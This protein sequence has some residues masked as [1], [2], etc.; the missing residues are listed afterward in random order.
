MTNHYQ[1]QP[2]PS[3]VGFGY[4]SENDASRH[5]TYP[6]MAL[7][8]EGGSKY[9]PP[10][11]PGS[12]LKSAL[13]VPGTPGRL[14]NPL[15]PTFQE[16]QVLE[17]QEEMTDKRQAKD[18]VGHDTGLDVI[19]NLSN[20][21][22]CHIESE[23]ERTNSEDDASRRQLQLQSHRSFHVGNHVFHLQRHQVIT[24]TQQPP[25]MGIGNLDMAADCSPVH[26]VRLARHVN[27]HYICAMETR[28]P[29]SGESRSLLYCFRRGFLRLQHHH[30][31]H[32]C[33]NPQRQQGQW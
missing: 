23:D 4:M 29:A 15:S 12:P 27:G 32:W 5:A 17:K 2:Q 9:M 30:V 20:Y 14:I 1:P 21:F 31:G 13:K 6:G 24:A 3:D 26:L 33:R 7:E 22:C 8:E 28:S 19:D 10:P 16:E 25:A 11:T 18:L